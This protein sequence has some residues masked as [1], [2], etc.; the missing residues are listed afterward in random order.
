MTQRNEGEGNK[1]AAR[2]YNR[3]TREFVESTDIEEKARDA[4]PESE[5]EER[6]NLR[7]REKAA[8]RA[9]D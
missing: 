7:A 2:N 3:K 4:E 9:R 6:E 1:T 8:S 5:A